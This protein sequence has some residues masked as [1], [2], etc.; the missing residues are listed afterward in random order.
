MAD[1]REITLY[2]G[3]A[4]PKDIV[5]RALP[6]ADA[7]PGTTIYLFTGASP[8]KDIILRDPTAVPVSG[9]NLTLAISTPG[10]IALTGQSMTF[11]TGVALSSPG[12]V[13]IAGQ[14]FSVALGIALGSGAISITGQSIDFAT[15]LALDAGAI[16][17]AGQ[18]IGLGLGI[19]LSAG[20]ITID[21]QDVTLDLPSGLALAIDSPGIIIL[22]GSSVAL[23]LTQTTDS[24]GGGPGWKLNVPRGKKRSRKKIEEEQAALRRVIENIA[25]GGDGV[26]PLQLEED[27]EELILLLLLS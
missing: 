22:A 20:A 15:G 2:S 24:G 13:T 16:G 1:Q 4:T 6:V 21:G 8:D 10:A 7:S 5:L 12:T 17:I 3:D 18:E 23:E 9:G 19:E 25:E 14:S 26:T 11:G 27:E